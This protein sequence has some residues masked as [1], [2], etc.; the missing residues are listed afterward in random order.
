MMV[1]RQLANTTALILVR[2]SAAVADA[3]AV[4]VMEASR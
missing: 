2:F 4:M 1:P 3:I